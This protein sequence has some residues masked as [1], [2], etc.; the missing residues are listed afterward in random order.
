MSG[1]AKAV[2]AVAVGLAVAIVAM[3]ISCYI[4]QG[5][6][7]P[8]SPEWAE[9]H[10]RLLSLVCAFNNLTGFVSGPSTVDVADAS[11]MA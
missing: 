3:A 7:E 1:T 9:N 5:F 6:P 11:C 10:K 2:L 8:D 4:V